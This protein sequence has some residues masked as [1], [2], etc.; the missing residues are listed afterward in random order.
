MLQKLANSL[1]C[2]SFSNSE[3]ERKFSQFKLTK[4]QLRISL[5]DKTIEGLMLWK[6][7]M[8]LININDKNIMKQLCVKYK[9]VF[10]KEKLRRL[11]I[12]NKV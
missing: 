10:E 3:I 9:E 2:L 8:D 11:I 5:S 7:N 6:M 12:K 4:R 1:L